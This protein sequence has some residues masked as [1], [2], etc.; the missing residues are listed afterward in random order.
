MGSASYVF[1]I[2]LYTAAVIW[3][4]PTRG[5]FPSRFFC[6]SDSD[7]AVEIKILSVILHS[8]GIFYAWTFLII[9]D[10]LE[11]TYAMHITN[12]IKVM[13]GLLLRN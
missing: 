11:V 2:V 3:V 1:A 10:L 13:S 5:P 6:S 12:I 7:C 8:V 4:E 9:L